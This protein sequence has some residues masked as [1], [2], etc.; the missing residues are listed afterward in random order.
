MSVSVEMIFYCPC[1][2]IW[3]RQNETTLN[4]FELR[5]GYHRSIEGF[6]RGISSQWN[7][8]PESYLASL[9]PS[10]DVAIYDCLLQRFFSKLSNSSD[11]RRKLERKVT[12]Q[13]VSMFKFSSFNCSGW[14][15]LCCNCISMYMSLNQLSSILATLATEILNLSTIW[16]LRC[17]S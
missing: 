13:L 1:L 5:S 15:D 16:F 6:T 8:V 9:I 10:P 7:N 11:K 14:K 12:F 2:L 3:F 4:D 17:E